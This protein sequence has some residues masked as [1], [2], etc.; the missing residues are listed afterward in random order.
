MRC[1]CQEYTATHAT[2]TWDSAA[3]ASTTAR[4][5]CSDLVVRDPALPDAAKTTVMAYILAD[6]CHMCR[7]N[8][9]L[10]WPNGVTAP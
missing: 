1:C 7:Y 6:E 3:N 8:Y 4:E 10:H 5:R 2:A 9:L